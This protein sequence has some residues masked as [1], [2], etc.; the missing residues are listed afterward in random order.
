MSSQRSSIVSTIGVAGYTGIDKL[1]KL[2]KDLECFYKDMIKVVFAEQP[3]Q[4]AAIR[5]ERQVNMLIL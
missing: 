2:R 3:D 1:K 4:D 5:L